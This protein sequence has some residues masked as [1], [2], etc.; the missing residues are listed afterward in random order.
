MK[1]YEDLVKLLNKVQ[2][3]GGL[4]VDETSICEYQDMIGHS[5]QDQLRELA[6]GSLKE[7]FYRVYGH[8]YG[9][10][11]AIRFFTKNSDKLYDILGER[12]ELKADLEDLKD[13]L[14]AQ[15]SKTEENWDKA[16][17]MHEAWM[18]EKAEKEQAQDDL[19]KAQEEIIR[20]KARLFDLMEK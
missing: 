15:K 2:A 5:T 13:E 8:S 11:E 7:S 18:N 12:D 19:K 14:K 17:K 3:T 1:Q 16:Q 10:V 6:N 20:L 4:D 9:T